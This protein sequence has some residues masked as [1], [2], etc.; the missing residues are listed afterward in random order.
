MDPALVGVLNGE[1]AA[2]IR[3]SGRSHERYL[4]T[5][6][7]V[8]LQQYASQQDT[9]PATVAGLNTASH[10]PTSQ[11]FVVP[12]FVTPAGAVPK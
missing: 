6:D 5:L 4:E 7:R 12:N 2:D 11:P 3:L 10:V 1:L 8:Y 9:V